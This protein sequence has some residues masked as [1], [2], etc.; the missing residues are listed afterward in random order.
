MRKTTATNIIDCDVDT[1][2]KM[3]FDEAYNRA[4]YM[5]ELGFT[6]FEILSSSDNARVI[7][8]VPKLDMP[9][10]VMKL[11]GS[12]FGYEEHGTLDRDKNLWSWK[13]V[14]NTMADKL[15]TEGT[16]KI[17]AAGEGKCRRTDTCTLEAKIFGVGGL[18]E[19]STEKEVRSAWSKETVFLTRW[20]KDHSYE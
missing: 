16:I 13:M 1:F 11:L 2:W 12:S 3:F 5:D 15:K 7:R 19:S 18:V 6:K 4:F 9:K 10:P 17:E 14:P 8:A 20:L